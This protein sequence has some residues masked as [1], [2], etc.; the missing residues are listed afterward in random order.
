LYVRR[1]EYSNAVGSRL[2]SSLLCLIQSSFE[3]Q[4]CNSEFT[5]YLITPQLCL[6]AWDNPCSSNHFSYPTETTPT[7][8][9]KRSFVNFFWIKSSVQGNTILSF[10]VSRKNRIQHFLSTSFIRRWKLSLSECDRYVYQDMRSPSIEFLETML[11]RTVY[12]HQKL[13]VSCI[14]VPGSTCFIWIGFRWIISWRIFLKI[15]LKFLTI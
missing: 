2:L 1:N 3:P 15:R 5:S 9:L 8:S 13:I 6:R 10:W 7:S 11:P 14:I 12:M 4:H